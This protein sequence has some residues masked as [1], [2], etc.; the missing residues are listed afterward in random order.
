MPGL[1]GEE[2]RREISKGSFNKK[3]LFNISVA[4]AGVEVHCAGVEVDC[5]GVGLGGAVELSCQVTGSHT[6]LY[7]VRSGHIVTNN[8]ASRSAI[9]N[10]RII[11]RRKNK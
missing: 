7:W 3:I 6:R 2:T 4:L 9:T 1:L 11:W 8:S 10:V 5:A